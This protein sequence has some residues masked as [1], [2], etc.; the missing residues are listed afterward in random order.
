MINEKKILSY[1]ITK[2]FHYERVNGYGILK[3]I[4]GESEQDIISAIHK[5]NN[6]GLSEVPGSMLMEET[7]DKWAELR[8]EEIYK[9]KV[10]DA[11]FEYELKKAKEQSYSKALTN[12]HNK[13]NKLINE[14]NNPSMK[15]HYKKKS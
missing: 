11:E 2:P 6:F 4:K 8:L 14:E 1:L 13:Y 9:E 10:T 5:A 12:I 3:D 15:K 7:G